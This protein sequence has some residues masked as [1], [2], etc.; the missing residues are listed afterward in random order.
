MRI[1][2]IVSLS[3]TFKCIGVALLG[4]FELILSHTSV[5]NS[6]F[7]SPIITLPPH[8]TIASECISPKRPAPPVTK[9]TF[10]ER[11]NINITLYYTFNFECF[12]IP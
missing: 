8:S 9:A 7:K 2:L 4:Y 3:R 12:T 11:S 5:A 6:R 10:L 1:F